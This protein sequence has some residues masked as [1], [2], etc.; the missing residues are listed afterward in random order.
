M[1]GSLTKTQQCAPYPSGGL[2]WEAVGKK[3]AGLY[4]RLGRRSAFFYPDRVEWR[5]PAMLSQRGTWLWV[6]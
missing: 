6:P 5:R 1:T 2:E 4:L 3:N